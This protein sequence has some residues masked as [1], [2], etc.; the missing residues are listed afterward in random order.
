MDTTMTPSQTTTGQIEKAV[1]SYRAMLVK[2][3]PQFGA[4]P[5][6]QVLGQPELAKDMFNLFRARVEAVSNMI[7]RTVKVDPTRTPQQ[8]LAATGRKQYVT[9]AVV[10]TMPRGTGDEVEVVFFKVDRNLSDDELVKE[11]ELRGL[12]PIDP[13]SLAAVNETDPAFGDKYPNA[14]HW[15]NASGMFCYALFDRWLG[16]R[17][18]NVD[19]RDDSWAD[20]WWFAG[21]RK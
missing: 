6:Q 5:V 1:A 7:V 17:A 8:A 10:A 12:T 20:G 15:K 19:R 4:G 9:D 3:A 14:T 11:Y 18:M 16:E 21:S 13:F 2:H